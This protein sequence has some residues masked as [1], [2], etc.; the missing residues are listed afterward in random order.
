M[1]CP[2]CQSNP[3]NHLCPYA[4]EPRC[5]GQCKTCY[6]I[7]REDYNYITDTEGNIFCSEECFK[8]Y[9]GYKEKEWE[10]EDE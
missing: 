7:L 8:E 5:R 1:S 2:I 3:H 4:P 9:H 10:I 6:T